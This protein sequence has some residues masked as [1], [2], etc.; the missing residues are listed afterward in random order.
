M[1]AM[2]RRPSLPKTSTF[3]A[4]GVAVAALT[5]YAWIYVVGQVP[6]TQE[7]PLP[8]PGTATVTS[9]VDVK[10]GVS[11]EATFKTLTLR[12]NQ[13]VQDSRCPVDVKCIEAG[14]VNANV[15]L[16]SGTTTETLNMPSDEVPHQFAGYMISIARVDPPRMNH[17]EIPLGAYAITFHI[18]TKQ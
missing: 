16:T 2:T 6:T 7:P 18:E 11:G 1:N 3:I 17:Q 9:S 5:V 10:L 4:M 15:T 8:A 13:L 14:A 12:F